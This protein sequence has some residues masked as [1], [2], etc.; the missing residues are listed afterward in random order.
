[1]TPTIAAL[2]A[3]LI[4]AATLAG[5]IAVPMIASNAS[6]Q[7]RLDT[8]ARLLPWAL[9]TILVIWYVIA[10]AVGALGGFRFGDSAPTLAL[11]LVPVALGIA[12]IWL[13]PS[14]GRLLADPRLQPTLIA[15]QSIRVI[16]GVVFLLLIPLG[17]LPAFFG[18]PAGVGDVVAGLTAWAAGAALRNGNRQPAIWWNLFGLLDF[19]VAIG[20]G[21]LAA[22]GLTNLLKLAPSTLALSMPPLV[23]VPT[24]AV[25]LF[26]LLHAASLRFLLSNAVVGDPGHAERPATASR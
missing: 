17:Q 10:T 13:I 23:V 9:A 1:M 21:I 24:F 12:A 20:I 16:F 8:R 22:P 5:T 19:A 4:A 25:P 18:I 7:A 26:I 6:A 11:G 2:V 14:L 15:V 3:A